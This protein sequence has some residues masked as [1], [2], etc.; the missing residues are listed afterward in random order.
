MKNLKKVYKFNINHSVIRQLSTPAYSGISLTPNSSFISYNSW[1]IES[2]KKKI[3]DNTWSIDDLNLFKDIDMTDLTN[4]L[5]GVNLSG[6]IAVFCCLYTI[7]TAFYG[8]KLIEYFQLEK[9][10]PKLAKVIYYRIKFQNYTI[11]FNFILLSIILFIQ[12]AIN[13]LVLFGPR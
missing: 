12:T 1:S 4:S 5:A 7:I 9:K 3:I 11:L 13:F 8:N 6:S 2:L 10:Y